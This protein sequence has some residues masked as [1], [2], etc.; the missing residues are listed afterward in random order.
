MWTPQVYL[1]EVLQAEN[2]WY[3]VSHVSRID[4]CCHTDTTGNLLGALVVVWLVV[5]HLCLVSSSLLSASAL[6][7]HSLQ[8]ASSQPHHVW[9]QLQWSVCRT[10]YLGDIWS[11]ASQEGC[12]V[13]HGN[14]GCPI[15]SAD[16]LSEIVHCWC[17]DSGCQFIQAVYLCPSKLLFE[18]P[19][20][21]IWCKLGMPSINDSVAFWCHLVSTCHIRYYE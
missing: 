3:L 14:D 2:M 7:Q 5:A 16:K 8:L 17:L 21:P 10:R 20:A 9:Q 15:L 1:S 12:P 18:K 13:I 4:R 11:E 6:Y 19:K